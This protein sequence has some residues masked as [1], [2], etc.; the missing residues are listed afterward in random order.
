ML[1]DSKVIFR[2]YSGESI[3]ALGKIEVPSDVP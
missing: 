2:T 3:Y 1:T